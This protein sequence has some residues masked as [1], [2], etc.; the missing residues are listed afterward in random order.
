[1]VVYKL[2]LQEETLLNSRVVRDIEDFKR[3]CNV[4]ADNRLTDEI[5]HICDKVYTRDLFGK[6]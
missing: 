6:D 5:S 4:V 2:L 1:M 3:S